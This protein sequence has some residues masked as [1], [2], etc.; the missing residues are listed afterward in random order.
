MGD[1]VAD[2]RV[3]GV[4]DHCVE[5]EKKKKKKVRIDSG[6]RRT[7]FNGSLGAG[8]ELELSDSK[9]PFLR[10]LWKSSTA[11]QPAKLTIYVLQR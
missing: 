11:G 10:V 2:I 3:E 1:Y 4:P 9:Y 5:K 7:L 6:C 8:E